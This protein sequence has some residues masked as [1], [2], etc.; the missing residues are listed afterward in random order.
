MPCYS[1]LLTVLDIPDY[2][3]VMLAKD[4]KLSGNFDPVGW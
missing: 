2:G 1:C 4:L 3:S